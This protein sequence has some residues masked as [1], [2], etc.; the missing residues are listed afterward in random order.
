MT[1][2]LRDH[3]N[4]CNDPACAATRNLEANGARMTLGKGR[5]CEL[6]VLAAAGPGGMTGGRDR[7]GAAR[8][9]RAPWGIARR[10]D[11]RRDRECRVC[12]PLPACG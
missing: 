8:L 5:H 7:R 2:P 4:T 9:R 3:V 12:D 10:A 6:A 11:D 1:N